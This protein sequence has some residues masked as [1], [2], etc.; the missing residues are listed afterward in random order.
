MEIT[1]LSKIQKLRF[2]VNTLNSVKELHE[3]CKR[4]LYLNSEDRYFERGKLDKI[5]KKTGVSVCSHP[6]AGSVDL[7]D[8]IT[9]TQDILEH[10]ATYEKIKGPFKGPKCPD[11]FQ[12][13]EEE[14]YED[15]KTRIGKFESGNIPS[16]GPAKTLIGEIFR[17]I[18]YIQYRAFNDGDDF[19]VIGTPPFESYIFVLSQ[20][21]LLNYSHASYNESR[22]EYYFEFK[23]PVLEKMNY[24]GKI[25]TCIEDRLGRD[26]DLIKAQLLDLLDNGVLED[27]ENIWDSRTYKK[28]VKEKYW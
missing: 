20:V 24:D 28:I 21:D 4:F 14:F 9:I 27:R 5:S 6:E 25:S 17:A 7:S 11:R 15:L 18:N 13:F 19:F 12:I 23:E 26:G 2:L 10:E 3:D 22:G 8:H 16:S 1:Q